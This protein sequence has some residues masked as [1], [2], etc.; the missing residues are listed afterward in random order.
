VTIARRA[1]TARCRKHARSRLL[2]RRA[3]CS[4]ARQQEGVSGRSNGELPFRTTTRGGSGRRV[5]DARD[6]RTARPIGD[7]KRARSWGGDVARGGKAWRASGLAAIAAQRTTRHTLTTTPP[8]SRS[9][10]EATQ[11]A[12]SMSHTARRAGR[13]ARGAARRG[14]GRR[15][16]R[17]VSLPQFLDGAVDSGDASARHASH[18]PHS[19]RDARPARPTCPPYL[20]SERASARRAACLSEPSEPTT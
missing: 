18:A 14:E 16:E 7:S 10:G 6:A 1:S 4:A 9:R 11:P 8:R 20:K 3:R 15:G 12:E 17:T 5:S 13:L 19:P 2:A